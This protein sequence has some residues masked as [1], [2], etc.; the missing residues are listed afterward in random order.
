M[1][2]GDIKQFDFGENWKNF[3]SNALS[4]SSVYSARKEFLNL[5]NGE[6]IRGKAFVDI[7]FG[8]GLSLLIASEIGAKTVGCDIN[9]KCKEILEKN[10]IYFPGAQ[11][12]I[13]VITGSILEEDT[14][15]KIKSAS[16]QKNGKYN[17]VHSWGVLHHTGMMWEAIQKTIELVDLNGILIIAIYNRHWTSSAWKLIKAFYNVSN[18][19]IK[20][21][22]VF[23]FAGVIY[24]AKF[25]V[26][27]ENPFNQ[28][29]GMDFY[30]NVID[31]VGGYPY[32]Y[33]SKEE[34]VDFVE[35]NGFT[36][37]KFK[38]PKVPTGCN[39]FVFERKNRMNM[40][41]NRN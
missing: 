6:N 8:Q 30:Y 36:L 14:I 21:I 28:Q 20:Q 5:I 17:I 1:L 34:I 12:N 33:A 11:K 19:L 24:F 37:R 35:R 27:L 31:W 4:D 25:M 39:E 41:K 40:S 15:N 2:K 22:L 7:G 16:S 32:E 26:T 10:R 23:L 3:S 29:R 18:E 9:P 38:K 13:P